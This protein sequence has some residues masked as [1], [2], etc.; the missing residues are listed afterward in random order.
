MKHPTR[1]HLEAVR[2]TTYRPSALSLLLALVP[3]ALI[4]LGVAFLMSRWP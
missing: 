1:L 3:W 2:R 4:G